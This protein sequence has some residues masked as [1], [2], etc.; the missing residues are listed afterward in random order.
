MLHREKRK[1]GISL[2]LVLLLAVGLAVSASASET[3]QSA[4]LTAAFDKSDYA[5]GESVTVTFTLYGA[6]FDAAGFHITYDESSLALQDVRP[7][8]DLTVSVRRSQSGS[9]E[10]LMQ[11]KAALHPGSDG[12]TV[13]EVAFRAVTGGAKTL[14]FSSGSAAYLEGKSAVAYNGYQVL[15]VT[16]GVTADAAA[17]AA[18]RRA[19]ADAVARLE[20]EVNTALE[21]GVTV[22]QR[23]LLLRCL[24]SG[25]AAIHNAATQAAVSEA[26]DKALTRAA[27]IAEETTLEFPRLTALY[28]VEKN[29]AEVS[30]M[31]PAFSPE[32]TAYFLYNNRPL[33]G[34]AREFRGTTTPGVTVT[35]NGEAVSVAADGTFTF[36]VPF[37]ALENCST[38][39]LTDESTG[40]TATYAFFTFGYGVS[41]GARNIQVYDETG[42]DPGDKIGDKTVNNS[43]VRLTSQINKIRIGFDGTAAANQEFCVE[44]VGRNG[45]VLQT[46]TTA[47]GDEPETTRFCSDVISLEKGL[48]WV[49][50]RYRGKYFAGY[51]NGPIYKSGYSTTAVLINYIDPEDDDPTLIDTAPE[52]VELLIRNAKDSTQVT[53][54][55]EITFQWKEATKDTKARYES[56]VELSPDDFDLALEEQW[57][58]MKLTLKDG[59]EASVTGGNGAPQTRTLLADGTYHVAEYQQTFNSANNPTVMKKDSF[60]IDITVTAKDGIHKTDYRIRVNKSGKAAMIIPAAYRERELLIVPSRPI[61]NQSLTFD[62]VSITDKAGLPVNT[63]AALRDGTLT[64]SVADPTVA[65]WNGEIVNGSSISVDL[66]KQGKTEIALLYDDGETRLEGVTTLYVNYSV[67]ALA[68]TLTE[69]Y[70]RL[71]DA[72][73]GKRTYEDGAVDALK[74]SITAANQ[75]YRKYGSMSRSRMNQTQFDE[76]NDAVNT[77]RAD[78]LAFRYREIGTKLIAFDPLEDIPEEVDHELQP[79]DFVPK[80]IGATTADGEHVTLA[81]EWRCSPRYNDHTGQLSDMKYTF[82]LELPAGYVPAE[83]VELPSFIVNRQGKPFDNLLTPDNVWLPEAVGGRNQRAIKTVEQPAVLRVYRGTTL[84][85]ILRLT[86]E[87]GTGEQ[88]AELPTQWLTVPEDYDPD[89][90]GGSYLFTLTA[91]AEQ[92]FENR[93]WHWSEDFTPDK[94]VFQLR[95]QIIE[96]P[97]VTV[98]GLDS[99]DKIS[100]ISVSGTKIDTVLGK[101][102]YSD[103]ESFEITAADGW[104]YTLEGEQWRGQRLCRPKYEEFTPQQIVGYTWKVDPKGDDWIIRYNTLTLTPDPLVLKVGGSGKLHVK[105]SNPEEAYQSLTWD[106]ADEEIATVNNGVVSAL[107]A[108]QTTVTVQAET[109]NGTVTGTCTVIVTPAD[110]GLSGGD[111]VIDG[112]GALNG[113]ATSGDGGYRDLLTDPLPGQESAAGGNTAAAKPNTAQSGRKPQTDNRKPADGADTAPSGG[114]STEGGTTGRVISVSRGDTKESSG[115]AQDLAAILIMGSILLAAGIFRGKKRGED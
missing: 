14:T 35:F 17:D 29:S 85:E 1:R 3:G 114:D 53:W 103:I 74:A 91:L 4:E 109:E 62:A 54:T 26:L 78:C 34:M 50:L 41:G 16:T 83:G 77:L 72:E 90:V 49:L 7:G 75:V 39:A 46:F 89:N 65:S 100:K 8:A 87:T 44:L 80:T 93:I 69:A 112:G 51:D 104:K 21:R 45:R 61:R 68:E 92:K 86:L 43:V 102:V 96:P 12:I 37:P 10:L 18:L 115:S 9:L 24:Q 33:E 99:E 82:T 38:L 30:D 110:P 52:K 71:V 57:I 13:A 111:G 6:D 98:E 58:R 81:A 23:E 59:Q 56:T 55:D 94:R 47:S 106:S 107:K 27:E 32:R 20:T 105:E 48:N 88:Q 84:E 63:A 66:L 2:L 22:A 11:S 40:L 5:A 25:R 79:K 113:Q 101:T 97:T 60:D 15:A 28:D 95:V 31:Y 19:K 108:G 36:G 64:L 76:I 70:D 42:A 67:S 73:S